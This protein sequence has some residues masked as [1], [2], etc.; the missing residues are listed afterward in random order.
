MLSKFD[1]K[2]LCQNNTTLFSG[3]LVHYK[4]LVDQG[5]LQHDPYQESVAT[6]LQNLLSRLES[7]EREMEEYHV[8]F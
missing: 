8:K 6:E 2:F 4:N 5:K 7:Y 3:L 1:V